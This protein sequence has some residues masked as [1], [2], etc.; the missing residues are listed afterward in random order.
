MAIKYNAREMF[1]CWI[2]LYVR[3]MINIT[4]LSNIVVINLTEVTLLLTAVQNI[5]QGC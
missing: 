3:G 2:I 1:C 4:N 5:F